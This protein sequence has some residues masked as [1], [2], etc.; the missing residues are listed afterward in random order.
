MTIHKSKGLEFPIVLL[1]FAN[2][3]PKRSSWMW[4]ETH[5]EDIG[6]KSVLTTYN[7]KMLGTPFGEQSEQERLKTMLDELN[8]VYVGLTR[9]ADEI[10]I[11]INEEKDTNEI[12]GVEK[13]FHQVL[14]THIK[15]SP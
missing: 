1:P 10:Y 15:F 5:K 13:F 4:L 11:S 12:N 6:I 8:V 14:L 7:K 2:K 3:R 9:A